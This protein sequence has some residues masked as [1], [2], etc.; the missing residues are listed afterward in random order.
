AQLACLS[1]CSEMAKASD[2]DLP[3]LTLSVHDVNCRVLACPV[4]YRS[5]HAERWLA[6]IHQLGAGPRE[7]V[8]RSNANQLVILAAGQRHLQ[9]CWTKPIQ[10]RGVNRDPGGFN[11]R[12][13]LA[14]F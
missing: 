6:Q 1:F 2:L 9:R 7:D 12:V 10:R 13:D 14:A 8:T 3:P 5:D 4:Y 11:F